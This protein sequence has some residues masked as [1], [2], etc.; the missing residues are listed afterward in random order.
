MCN[1]THTEIER[2]TY[3]LI[4]TIG[5]SQVDASENTEMEE[6]QEGM[7]VEPKKQLSATFPPSLLRADVLGQ[8]G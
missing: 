8:V 5:V 1:N 2:A 4:L 3:G 6:S 7:A